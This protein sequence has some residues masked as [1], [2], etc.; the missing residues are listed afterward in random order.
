MRVY[1]SCGIYSDVM[2][3]IRMRTLVSIL[4]LLFLSSC[5]VSSTSVGTSY[6]NINEMEEWFPLDDNQP[7]IE[8]TDPLL[9]TIF[10]KL[11][12][13]WKVKE[14]E[15]YILFESKDVVQMT[16]YSDDQPYQPSNDA[17]HT[18]IPKLKLTKFDITDTTR[19]LNSINKLDSL[20]KIIQMNP[21]CVFDPCFQPSISFVHFNTLWRQKMHDKRQDR[22]AKRNRKPCKEFDNSSVQSEYQKLFKSTPRLFSEGLA[23]GN[24]NS[25]WTYCSTNTQVN[26]RPEQMAN[27]IESIVELINS[28]FKKSP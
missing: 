24:L 16:F 26:I 10:D 13:N 27:E 7:S 19:L 15:S 2:G 23:L 6:Y 12:T 14:T 4:S 25:N 1:A 11:P 3:N 17:V 21:K 20:D 8:I 22:K 5:F 28:T 9:L 18:T